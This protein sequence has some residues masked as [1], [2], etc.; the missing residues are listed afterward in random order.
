V[1]VLNSKVNNE[2]RKGGGGQPGGLFG[3]GDRGARYSKENKITGCC[4]DRSGCA[5]NNTDKGAPLLSH[6]GPKKGARKGTKR[7]LC[8]GG[9]NKCKRQKRPWLGRIQGDGHNVGWSPRGGVHKKRMRVK[10]RKRGGVKKM[11]LQR[12]AP[13]SEK[14]VRFFF[15]RVSISGDEQQT[16]IGKRGRRKIIGGRLG[17]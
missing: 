4:T 14:G 16:T 5:S 17:G 2:K 10:G 6:Q 11:M 15:Q 3:P 9:G 8:I 7:K 12:S 13:K 1:G